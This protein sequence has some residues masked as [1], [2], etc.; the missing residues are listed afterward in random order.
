MKQGV[1]KMRF[2]MMSYMGSLL[3]ASPEEIVACAVRAGLKEIDWVGTY[4]YTP[5]KLRQICDD[6][7]LK[8]CCYTFFVQEVV[9]RQPGALDHVREG[10]E[11]A[12]I[13]G[14]PM[15]MLPTAPPRNAATR[16]ESQLRWL[17]AMFACVEVCDDPELVLTV[18]NFHGSLS[19]LIT[20]D[21]Y[22]TFKAAIPRLKLTFDN[23]NTFVGE[24]PHAALRRLLPD[25]VH[26]HLKDWVLAEGDKGRSNGLR[27]GESYDPALIGEGLVDSRE[28]LRILREGGYTGTVNIEYEGKY[29][30]PDE[31][32]RRAFAYLNK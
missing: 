5:Q 31:A 16:A 17:D 21:D 8:V 30:Q 3:G 1:H 13:L 12:H 2:S 19:P 22:F 20:A 27:P 29:W 14:A 32:L 24:D 25:V 4:G 9:N 11:V 28:T 10:Y 26:V 6:A 18:E 7:G 15:V 23:G